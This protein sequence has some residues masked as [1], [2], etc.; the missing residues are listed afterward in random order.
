MLQVE[1]YNSKVPNGLLREPS[2]PDGRHTSRSAAV[3][4]EIRKRFL[5]EEWETNPELYDEIDVE[6]MR[7]SEWF[8]KRFLLAARRNESEAYEMMKTTL[9]WRK[10]VEI[11]TTPI[12]AFPSEFFRVGGLFQ[13][14]CDLKGNPVIYMRIRMHQKIVEIREPIQQFLFYIINKVD[15]E[16]DG[17]GA[18]IVFDC[19]GAGYA[20]MDLD[21]LKVLTEVAF[22]YFPFCIKYVIVYELSWMLNAFRRIAM[23]F[24]P[25]TFTRIVHF[26]D[27]S[28]ITDYIAKEN[29]P[30]FMGGTCT[31]DYRY[32]PDGC[33]PVEQVAQDRGFSLE[34]VARIT[35]KFKPYLDEADAA[36]AAK[37]EQESITKNVEIIQEEPTT[38]DCELENETSDG[39]I[40]IVRP[41]CNIPEQYASLYPRDM[42]QFRRRRMEKSK[43]SINQDSSSKTDWKWVG[44]IL[45][46]NNNNRK[47]LA[48]KIQS[49]NAAQYTVSPNQGVILCG[50]FVC[51]TVTIV[52]QSL[53]DNDR[54]KF[55]VLMCPDVNTAGD[56][57]NARQ[58]SRLFIERSATNQVYSHKLKSIRVEDETL[59]K[60]DGMKPANGETG[61]T[62]IE[63]EMTRLK[64]RCDQ[65]QQTQKVLKLI[66]L[67]FS[68]LM[69]ISL[70]IMIFT[71]DQEKLKSQLSIM[72]SFNGVKLSNRT[73]KP[74]GMHSMR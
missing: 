57:A 3:V 15:Q 14:E 32:V 30:D 10:S 64:S 40:A 38:I 53:V 29:L 58:F 43:W 56:L 44:I 51:I 36:I 45:I 50:A 61:F 55:M 70:A 5:K 33:P 7:R 23:T 54:D 73:I 62:Q 72:T 8:V 69:I 2:N 11:S 17:K 31:R 6:R 46:R 22:K 39:S 20:N 9:A 60:N 47:P 74:S 49:T 18:V 35:E 71:S 4:E 68:V 66:I 63:N 59:T 24:I 67:L 48:F 37:L 13:Y 16:S 52:D 12:N 21:M 41:K 65:L 25:S 28:N 19:S 42:I 34:D 1:S 27:K 26:A